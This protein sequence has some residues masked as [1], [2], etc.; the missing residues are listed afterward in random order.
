[1]EIKEIDTSKLP[2]DGGAHY[3]RLIFEK[4]PYLLQHAENPI[5]W[6]PWNEEALA[7]AVAENKPIFL[8][9]GYA[10]CHW[11]HVM[12]RESF[13]DREIAALLNRHF[14]A[15]KVDREERPDLDAIYMKISQEVT[16]SGGWPLN[17]ILT[18]ERKPFLVGTY[19]PKK[20]RDGRPGLLEILA[21]T[22][23]FWAEDRQ[24][25]VDSANRVV[26]LVSGAREAPTAPAGADTELFAEAYRQLEANYDRQDG[27]FGR[28]PKFPVP[29]QY[30]FLL[31]HWRRTGEEAALNMV[32]RSLTALR[33][34]GIYDQ[35]GFGFHRYS[36]DDQF[37]LPHF[38][39]ML[40]DQ[41]L[42][43][44]AYLE[45]HQAT[46][47]PLLAETARE[48][49]TYVARDLTAPEGGFYSAEDAES[50][51]EEGL[52]YLWSHQE[53]IEVLGEEQGRL[54]TAKYRIK[55]EGNFKDEASGEQQGLNIPHL[56]RDDTDIDELSVSRLLLLDKRA[57]RSRPLRDDKILT[58]WNGLMI[59]ALARGGRV[60]DD[61][62]LTGRA[63]RA[64][65]F[66]LAQMKDERGRL[67]RSYRRGTARITAFQDDY[68]YLIWGLLELFESSFEPRYLK[69]A[70]ALNRTMLELF[71]DRESGALNFS[72]P[73]NEKLVMAVREFYD[74]ALPSGNS[75]A[76]FN[77]A[78]LAIFLDDRDLTARAEKL[79][80]ACA[81]A[82]ADYPAGQTMF[83]TGLDLLRG[84]AG[85]IV[86][87]GK[88]EQPLVRQALRLINATY[89]PERVVLF[90]EEGE[91]GTALSELVPWLDGKDSAGAPVTV[92]IC[93][94][95]SCRKSLNDLP[96]LKEELQKLS[97][98]G[99]R[100][101]VA[102]AR[103]IN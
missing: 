29:H 103:R 16:G 24:K 22:A 17:L 64:A 68:A 84:P 83:L 20:T 15:I 21:K 90:R 49:F 43:A 26:E 37:L 72:G 35:V 39:K 94:D 93:Q 32:V 44:L 1:M 57:E 54:F 10:T 98:A 60:L 30:L 51:G 73:G 31:R 92:Y 77:L 75:V 76:L 8:S 13:A 89:A 58:A 27:G 100:L 85:E 62:G 82:A 38:E 47:I 74:G 33:Q 88:K 69:E 48:I 28:A 81:L 6:Y 61:P 91:A 80:A 96:E 40:Y 4:S 18:P 3:N 5:D 101:R 42:L 50:E 63:A 102:Q 79:A 97:T 71:D 53:I 65:G 2:A 56:G 67:R 34:G 66:I 25:L 19:F 59:A 14:I 46:G 52:Y 36:T 12:A 87:A 9:I 23:E 45:A 7:R 95:F 70:A 86:V 55:P 41:A 11:C 99:R 78:K